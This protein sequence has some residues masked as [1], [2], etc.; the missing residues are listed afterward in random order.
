MGFTDL[1]RH[2]MSFV[3]RGNH[4]YTLLPG[5]TARGHMHKRTSRWVDYNVCGVR[6]T[7]CALLSI[8]LIAFSTSFMY[9]VYVWCFWPPRINSSLNTNHTN[10]V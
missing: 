1:R 7:L 8:I 6:L 5:N 4:E 9:V 3:A 2:L 10:P